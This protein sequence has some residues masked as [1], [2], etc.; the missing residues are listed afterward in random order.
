MSTTCGQLIASVQKDGWTYA[1]NAESGQ[2]LWQFPPVAPP[3]G[4]PP[5]CIGPGYSKF[6]AAANPRPVHGD[7]D[8]RRPGAAWNDIYIVRAGGESLA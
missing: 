2:C 7:D 4:A 1:V 8:Y 5:R 3:I 6:S